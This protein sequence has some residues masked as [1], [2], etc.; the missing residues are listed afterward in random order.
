[1][2]AG[3]PSVNIYWKPTVCWLTCLSLSGDTGV[4][5]KQ[6]CPQG[7]HSVMGEAVR[8]RLTQ[9]KPAME[10]RAPRRPVEEPWITAEGRE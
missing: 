6:S 3:S 1:M 9:V 5:V 4:T 7:D 8:E 10:P 2:S